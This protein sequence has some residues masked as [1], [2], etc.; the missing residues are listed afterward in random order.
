VGFVLFLLFI[1]VPIA[2]LA[3]IVSVAREIGV[4]YTLAALFG[5]SIAGSILAKRQGLG[6][7]YRM[8]TMLARGQMPSTE[9]VDGALILLGGA[10]LLTPGFL[11]DILGISLLLPP[12]RAGIRRLARRQLRNMI[13]RHVWVGGARGGGSGGTRRARV[14]RVS[15]RRTTGEEPWEDEGGTGPGPGR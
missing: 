10:L 3:V 12:V 13:D 15:T 14:V 8:R 1:V 6:V 9:V 11:T 7:W 4:L 2:E 5:F